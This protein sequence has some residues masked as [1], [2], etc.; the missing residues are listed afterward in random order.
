MF[1]RSR[2]LYLG[3]TKLDTPENLAAAQRT[4]GEFLCAGA[5]TQPLQARFRAV[6]HQL[7]RVEYCSL[8]DAQRPL[9]ERDHYQ[10]CE[11]SDSV[12][13]SFAGCAVRV[14]YRLLFIH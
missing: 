5:F 9:E 12:V 14:K 4:A 2:F 7:K 8:A 10:G 13:G 3:D 11:V 6:R 1:P